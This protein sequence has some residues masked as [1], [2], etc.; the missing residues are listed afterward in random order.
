MKKIN[1][2]NSPV[3]VAIIMDG[4]RR[5]AKKRNL[6]AVAGHKKAL[7]EVVEKIIEEA[8]NLGIKYLTFWAWST[9]NWER[10]KKEVSGIMKL[11]KYALR[12]KV[13][14]FSKKGARLKVIG[15]ISGFSPDLQKGIQAAIK[16]TEK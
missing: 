2:K 10:D 9:E 6:P 4:N 12:S 7:D 3:H 8:G 5:W 14:S 16:K 11:F 13:D 15:D 1:N